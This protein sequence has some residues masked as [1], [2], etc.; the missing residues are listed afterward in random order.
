[1]ELD[2]DAP[3]ALGATHERFGQVYELVEVKPYTRKSDGAAT[4]LL[5]WISHCATCGD[6]FSVKSGL[7]CKSLNRRCKAHSAPM[8]PASPEAREERRACLTRG[9]A[10]A[11]ANRKARKHMLS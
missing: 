9:R 8:K 7:R 6:A 3:P 2:L 1:M 4:H 5:T 10:T 11:R